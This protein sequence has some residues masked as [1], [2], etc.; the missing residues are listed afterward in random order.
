MKRVSKKELSPEELE[1]KLR[2]PHGEVLAAASL[3]GVAA[4]AA[5]GAVVGPV[6][7]I[8]GGMIGAAV[9]SAAG[10]IITEENERRSFHDRELDEDI[11]VTKGDLGA[12][13]PSQPAAKRGVYS[14]ASAGVG[15]S[16][17]GHSAEGPMSSIDED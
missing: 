5:V 8:V 13:E 2:K 10:E 9:G 11:G 7:A 6:G 17:G 4:G 16:T 3:A 14:A 12:A 15:T 1:A